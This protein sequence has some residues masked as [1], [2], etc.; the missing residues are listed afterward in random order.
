L[1]QQ[2]IVLA[3]GKIN[4]TLSGFRSKKLENLPSLLDAIVPSEIAFGERNQLFIS[5][6]ALEHQ[7]EI[8]TKMQLKFNEG[9]FIVHKEIR[10]LSNND[11]SLKSINYCFILDANQ[12]RG[13]LIFAL[14]I[15]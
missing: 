1:T 10:P 6:H 2:K 11:F 12:R 15:K 9:N 7:N 5:Q 4:A 3:K 14:N 13:K 8:R